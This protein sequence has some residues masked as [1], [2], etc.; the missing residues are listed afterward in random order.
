[1]KR[2]K[3]FSLFLAALAAAVSISGCGSSEGTAPSSSGGTASAS[4]EP[5]T[6]TMMVTTRPSG[7]KD[8]YLDVLPQAVKEKYPN[9]DVEVEQLPTDQYKQTVRLKFS[10]GQGPDMFNWWPSLQAK[11]LVDAGYVKDLSDY[12]TLSKYNADIVKSYTFGDK[13]YAIPNGTSFLCTW[14][15]KDEFKTAGITQLPA[16]W[17]EFL[18]ACS[19]LKAAGFTPVTCGD[20][21]SFVI[22]FGMYQI[23]A[24][25]VYGPNMDFDTDLSTGKTKFTDPV[26]VD[27]I[28][29]MQTLYTKDYVI[30]DSLGISQDQ[31]RQAFC[32]G[33]AAMI[34]DG[35]FGY[36][37][38]MQDGKVKFERGM[39]CIPSNAKDEKFVY[40]LTPSTGLFVSANSQNQ[41]AIKEVMDYWLTPGTDLND[42]WKTMNTDISCFEGFTDSRSLINEYLER[43]KD[44]ESIYNCNNAWPEGVSDVMC[45]KFQ[46][47]VTG[48]ASA[49]DVAAAMQGKYEELTAGE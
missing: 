18:D 33:D 34:F 2:R 45:S 38:L 15:N 41:A 43:Y 22:Q 11:D 39:F 16:N 9:I 25:A 21:Q 29:K 12:P 44:Q 28:S 19:K 37:T 7:D 31:S 30:S 17:D 46:E 36:S 1:M 14:Y 4:G 13:V 32:D 8:F 10:S 42:Q 26:W 6:L 49:E 20:K 40:N 5:A 3:G 27:T 23:A 35:S 24:S 47:A 48:A